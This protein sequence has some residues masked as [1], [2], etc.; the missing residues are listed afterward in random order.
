MKKTVVVIGRCGTSMVCGILDRLNIDM[1]TGYK[2]TKRKRG[3][4]EQGKLWTF[5]HNYGGSFRNN[6]FE[7]K[8]SQDFIRT[9]KKF[10]NH[11]IGDIKVKIVYHFFH[12]L[13]NYLM[14]FM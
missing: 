13:N 11:I 9:Y 3:Y 7:G 5:L 1:K 6:F 10:E 2:D 12:G 14:I 8:P 4:Y